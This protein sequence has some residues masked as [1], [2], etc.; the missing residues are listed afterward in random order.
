MKKIEVKK[1][2]LMGLW[3]AVCLLLPFLTGQIPEIGSMLSPM[4]IPVLLCG[5][6]CGWPYGLILGLV[7]P[8]VR[9][10]LFGMPPIFPVG[11]AMMFELAAYGLAAGL[12]YKLLPKK[13]VYVYVSL[14]L[15]MLVG[16]VVWGLASWVIYTAAGMP[17]TMEMFLAGAFIKAVPGIICHIVLIPPIV[18]AFQYA[19]FL[20]N[21]PA[22]QA[23]K[24]A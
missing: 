20:K 11:L 23:N 7:A 8:P 2:V 21:P 9:F 10:L 16:R 6:T 15:S 12:F 5:F 17:F 22:P 3:L 14:I 24:M 19:G 1:L 4:H 18:I 13:N